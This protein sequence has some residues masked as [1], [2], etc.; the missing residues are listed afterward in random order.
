MK[1]YLAPDSA[2]HSAPYSKIQKS[3]FLSN[4]WPQN[5]FYTK[6]LASLLHFKKKFVLFATHVFRNIR[7]F[8]TFLTVF[9]TDELCNISSKC[10]PPVNISKQYFYTTDSISLFHFEIPLFTTFSLFLTISEVCNISNKY[11]I[12]NKASKKTF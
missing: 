8:T 6:N 10:R 2:L 5:Y 7:F 3:T 9:S 4:C 12:P 11:W 1:Y